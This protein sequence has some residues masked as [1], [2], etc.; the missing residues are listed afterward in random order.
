MDTSIFAELVSIEIDTLGG[1][2]FCQEMFDDGRLDPQ[3]KNIYST[4][5]ETMFDIDRLNGGSINTSEAGKMFW[6]IIDNADAKHK[7]TWNYK[8]GDLANDLKACATNMMQPLY[9]QFCKT[10]ISAACQPIVDGN[11]KLIFNFFY[12]VYNGAYWFK[13]FADALSIYVDKQGITDAETLVE[14]MIYEREHTG[15]A[16]ILQGA[17]TLEQIFKQ[18]YFNES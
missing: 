2:Y 14:K 12:A 8:G 15:N 5:G 6:A 11:K 13:Y 16:L 18:A 10:Y 4:S 17:D 7:W 1:G 3:Y 9:E